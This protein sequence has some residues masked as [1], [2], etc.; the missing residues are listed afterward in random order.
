MSATKVTEMS[1][2]EMLRLVNP[3]RVTEIVVEAVGR[4]FAVTEDLVK[5]AAVQSLYEQEML[6][7]Q[8]LG[9]R[10]EEIKEE[11]VRLAF[12]V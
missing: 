6:Y 4:G 11:I 9:V 2:D 3:E 12:Y 10:R 1:M 7:G 8:M 5:H